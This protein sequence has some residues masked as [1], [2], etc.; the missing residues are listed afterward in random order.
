MK[1]ARALHAEFPD[2]SFDFTAKVEHILR[3]RALFPELK[4]LGCAFVVSAVESLSD[5]VLARLR[6]GH[7]AADVDVALS[8]L[9]AAGIALQPTLVAFTPWTTLDDYVAQIDYFRSRGLARHVPP[10]QLAIRLL[11]PPGSA[12]LQE[13]ETREWIGELDREAFAYRWSHPDPRMDALYEAVAARVQEGEESEEDPLGTWERVRALAYAA[14]GRR[15]ADEPMP[16]VFRPD[17]P[18][19]SEHWFC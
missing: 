11:V 17:P 6:K 13:P 3:R 12:L 19:L 16:P 10:I 7:R 4:R 15:F 14:A 1:I 18:R 2:V 8:I 5:V 9:D